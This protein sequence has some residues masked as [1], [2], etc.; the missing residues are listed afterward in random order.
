MI[1]LEAF[2]NAAV[3][4]VVS[5]AATLFVLGYSPA[6]SLAVTLMFFGL[7]FARSYAI[8]WAFKR[9]APP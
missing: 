2:A 1:G 4:F 7:S 8:R 3:G 6:G 9:W 5:Y